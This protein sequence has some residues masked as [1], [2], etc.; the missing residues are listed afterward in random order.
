MFV[1]F[2]YRTC[3]I[4]LVC[5]QE[6]WGHCSVFGKFVHH[7]GNLIHNLTTRIVNTAFCQ[8]SGIQ[9][10][11]TQNRFKYSVFLWAPLTCGTSCTVGFTRSFST[12]L[13]RWFNAAVIVTLCCPHSYNFVSA[14]VFAFRLSKNLWRHSKKHPVR[15]GRC[16]L[17]LA[18][19]ML[20]VVVSTK[21]ITLLNVFNP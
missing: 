20:G 5:C 7:W 10:E 2:E 8:K 15:R 6:F 3:F 4:V 11:C 17:R 1:D 16:G 13:A 18:H 9:S 21:L 14:D 19:M 12:P